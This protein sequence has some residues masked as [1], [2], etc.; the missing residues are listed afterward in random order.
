MSEAASVR[1][2][3]GPSP[4]QVLF[5]HGAGAPM[6][7]DFMNQMTNL[8]VAS[9]LGV[10]RFE[11]PYMAQR[12]QGGSKRPP[13]S[14]PQLLDAFRAQVAD[15]GPADRLIIGGKS[16]GGRVAT[17]LADEL[18]V[19]GAFCLGYPFHP[20]GKPDKTRTQHLQDLQTP[21]LICQGTR[22]TLGNQEEVAEYSLSK[23]VSLHWLEDGNH[24]LKPRVK[25]GFT[26]AQHMQAAAVAVASFARQWLNQ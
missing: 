18:G 17:L 23:Q 22:D 15:L 11:F 1:L 14:M 6:D 19:A 26:H 4:V 25:S 21:T 10:A 7:S 8:L 5:A 16:M 24:D 12:R 20:A 13:N 3:D 9:G 2:T